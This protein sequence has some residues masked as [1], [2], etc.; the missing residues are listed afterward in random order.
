[1]RLRLLA[2][3]LGLPACASPVTATPPEEHRSGGPTIVLE[4]GLGDGAESWKPLRAAL[5]DDLPVFAW[6]RA[7]YR[8]GA[9]GELIGGGR[10]WPS[11][12]DGRRTGAEIAAHLHEKLAQAGR[13]PPYVL[14]SHSIGANY[15][16]SFAMAYPGEVA[17]LVFVD[18]R[19]P[20]FNS[21]CKAQGLRLCEMPS[22]LTALL[23]PAE[24][25]EIRGLAETEAALADLSSIRD[26]PFTILTAERGSPTNDRRMRAL[27]QSY[28][29]SF[30][31]RFTNGRQVVIADSGHYIHRSDPQRVAGEI[32]EMAR[33]RH[34]P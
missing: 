24:R 22:I 29:A 4:A 15:A 2:G 16:L 30:A 27:W 25:V 3:L 11:D 14:V 12:A 8:G 19:L 5:P 32:L 31:A 13:R 33:S 21:A 26:I 6:S 17:G 7:G 10:L 1:M 20:G 23:S 18:P 9:I 34:L 28:S